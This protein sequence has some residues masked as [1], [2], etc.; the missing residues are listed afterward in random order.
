[1]AAA[2]CELINKQ[3]YEFIKGAFVNK[4][5][6]IVST[7]RNGRLLANLDDRAACRPAKSVVELHEQLL[8]AK[9]SAHSI[10]ACSP[11]SGALSNCW[12]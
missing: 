12:A 1:M 3:F 2:N 9:S 8:G 10:K 4:K 11:G 6:L 5:K 7:V